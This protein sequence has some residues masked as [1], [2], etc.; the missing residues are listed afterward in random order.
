VEE[1]DGLKLGDSQNDQCVT[2]QQIRCHEVGRTG[3]LVR[4]VLPVVV[5]GVAVLPVH[6]LLRGSLLQRVAAM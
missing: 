5:I 4:S 3:D 2:L 1:V 6:W